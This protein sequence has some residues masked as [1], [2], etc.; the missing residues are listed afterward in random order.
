MMNA[1]C[2]I[3]YI[4]LSGLRVLWLRHFTG[5]HPVLVYVAGLHPALIYHAP[6]G[7]SS[8]ALQGRNLLGWGIAP[9]Y[10]KGRI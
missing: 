3:K 7:Q 9:P 8:Q 2:G 4:A 1:M 6:S 5:L 10:K